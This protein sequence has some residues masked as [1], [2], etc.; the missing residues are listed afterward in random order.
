MR[1]V[2]DIIPQDDRKYNKDKFFNATWVKYS[3]GDLE[4]CIFKKARKKH[5][6]GGRNDMEK[7]DEKKELYRYQARMR[8]G[9]TVRKLVKENNLC[10]H[11]TLTYAE[12]MEDRTRAVRDFKTFV[13]RLNYRARTPTIPKVPYVAVMERQKRG[14]IHFHFA[15]SV[16]IDVHMLEAAWG[17]G[18]VKVEKHSGELDKVS[19]YLSK[20]LKK[21]MEKQDIN[22]EKQ[23]LYFNSKGLKRPAK[24]NVCLSDEK[25]RDVAARADV[26][27]AVSDD[28]EWL[29]MKA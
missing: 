28:T 12:N 20:Y 25:A 5:D 18:F 13:Q 16:Y 2:M 3:N 8:A 10:Y 26:R 27:V 7:T 14:A 6:L 4:V 11:W 15:T 19:G 23:K 17:H 24:G 21:E 29:L 9:S 22:G 1:L